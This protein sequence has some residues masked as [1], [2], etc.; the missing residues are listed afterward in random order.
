MLYYFKIFWIFLKASVM[1]WYIIQI[2]LW[3][4]SEVTQWKGFWNINIY[5]QSGSCIIY[6]G[7]KAILWLYEIRSILTFPKCQLLASVAWGKRKKNDVLVGKNRKIKAAI[8]F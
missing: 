3:Y 4:V 6:K 8:Y 7:H 1:L 5:N 2:L